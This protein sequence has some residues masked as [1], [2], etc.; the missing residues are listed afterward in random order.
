MANE[1]YKKVK[2]VEKMP[3]MSMFEVQLYSEEDTDI[4]EEVL[5]NKK[6]LR[7][8]DDNLEIEKYPD[9]VY[10]EVITNP[11][12]EIRVTENDPSVSINPA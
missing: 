2:L 1:T 4:P 3:E 7:K 6:A 9:G 12:G 5:K 8:D 11:G 10:K